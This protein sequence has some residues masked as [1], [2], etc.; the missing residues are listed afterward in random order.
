VCEG[1]EFF[2]STD[3]DVI[4]DFAPTVEQLGMEPWVQT[5]VGVETTTVEI[6]HFLAFPLEADFLAEGG[7]ALDWTGRSPL[8][9]TSSLERQGQLAGYDPMVFVGHPRAGILG[10]FD[11]YGVNPYGGRPGRGGEPGS[12]LVQTPTLALTN[13]LLGSANAVFDFDAME[14]MGTKEM[15]RIRTPTQPE[16]DQFAAFLQTGDPAQDVPLSQILTRSDEEQQALSDGTIGLGYGRNGQLDDWFTMLNL[17]FRFTALANS[18]THSTTTTEAGCPRNYVLV[19]TDEPSFLNDQDVADAV[20]AGR[21]VASYGPFMQLTLDDAIIGDE[22]V[23]SAE[24]LTA[25]VLVQ[26]PSWMDIDRVELYENGTLI[27]SWEVTGTAAARF[28]DQV[29]VT[30]QKDSWYVAI[31]MG[32]G[33]LAP[34]FTPVERPIIDLQAVVVEALGGVSAV[35]SFLEP[36]VPIPETYPITP[37]AVTNPIWVDRDGDGFDAPGVPEWMTEPEPPEDE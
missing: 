1:V 22:L 13:P 36:A 7:G 23:S 26:A 5:A 35:S 18:D 9:I 31:A 12:P 8:D 11:Q 15:Y 4:T 24:E 29:V 30:P 28:E 32:D 19:G 6:G 27:H 33:S 10:Y 16:L 21:V 2:S 17:G 20:K 37:F 34:V 25:T 3:Y 14:I